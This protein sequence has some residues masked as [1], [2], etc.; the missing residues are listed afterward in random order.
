MPGPDHP[1]YFPR[2]VSIAP[3]Q[4]TS[5]GFSP[6]HQHLLG[7]LVGGVTES[8]TGSRGGLIFR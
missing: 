1:N 6:G 2:V 7:E 4:Y 8:E 3:T 5:S